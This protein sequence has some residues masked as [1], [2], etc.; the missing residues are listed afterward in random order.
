MAKIPNWDD[1]TKLPT[2]TMAESTVLGCCL[3]GGKDVYEKA[4]GWIR[5]ENAFYSED[6]KK[7]WKV[8]EKLY[9]DKKA[10]D[11][12]TVSALAKDEYGREKISAYWLSSLS[13]NLP[14]TQSIE[15]Y[16]KIVWEKYIQ[17]EAAKS[18][19]KLYG[20]TTQEFNKTNE[21]LQEH[22]SL[23]NELENLQ[24]TSV[25]PM[26]EIIDKAEEAILKSANIIKFNNKILD[27]FAG[28]MT[29]KE[30][31]VLGGR[32]GHGKSVFAVN[33]LKGLVESGVK[34]MLINR[35]M[36]LEETM[37][38]VFAMEAYPE[39]ADVTYGKIRH[40]EFTDNEKKDLGN[41]V[42]KCYNK[43][44]EDNCI[45]VDHIRTLEDTLIEIGRHKPDVVIDDYIQLIKVNGIK[46]RDRRFEIEEIL[47]QYKWAC[48]E[49]DCHAILVSQ[50]NREIEKRFN[51]RPMMSD[52]AESGVIEQTAESA[53]F[54]YYPYN[55]NS[56]EHSRYGSEV[57]TAKT[58][59]GKIG[60]YECGFNGNRC[61][62]FYTQEEAALSAAKN[63]QERKN[64]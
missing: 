53:L 56:E 44:T 38:R 45:I 24:P 35:E 28:G 4:K 20:V 34:V 19:Q 5:E 55:F 21:V 63:S 17:R 36:T 9:K 57:I 2:N 27:S 61:K 25:K 6:H 62:F 42:H 49:H 1:I 10:I 22:K 64:I 59:Y 8:I 15:E 58:R 29:R 54:V 11:L 52:Y 39:F 33:I 50:L 12:V 14:T 7:V 18:A 43:Y 13:E 46:N 32:P 41:I 51:P 48:K 16:S 60:R 47:T 37:K 31:T 3:L 40:S 23:I 30:L 26:H